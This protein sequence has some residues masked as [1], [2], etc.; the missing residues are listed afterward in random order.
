MSA[1]DLITGAELELANAEG[2]RIRA[3]LSP[4]GYGDLSSAEQNAFIRELWRLEAEALVRLG[5]DLSV[6]RAWVDF[7]LESGEWYGYW[8]DKALAEAVIHGVF[9]RGLRIVQAGIRIRDEAQSAKALADR[10][11]SGDLLTLLEG[12]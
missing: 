6:G 8:I 10:E 1:Q 11:A 7:E 4:D 5:A 3:E 2:F 9:W 12:W